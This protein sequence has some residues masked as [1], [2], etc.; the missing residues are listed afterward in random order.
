MKITTG[1]QT[2]SESSKS[3]CP[4]QGGGLSFG[5][6]EACSSFVAHQWELQCV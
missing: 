1:A 4:G 3:G 6:G 2:G 5:E